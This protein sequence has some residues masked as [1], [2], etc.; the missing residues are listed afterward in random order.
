MKFDRTFVI[1][2]PRQSKRL[3]ATQRHLTER[4]IVAEPFEAFDYTIT[5][6]DTRWPWDMDNP[7]TGYKIGPKIVNLY[8]SHVVLWR[9]LRY[10]DGDAFLILE[11]DVRFD[12]DWKPVF[13]E[14]TA[15]LPPD[16]GMLYP[17]S[18]NTMGKATE[19]V[20]GRLWRVSHV[21]CTHCYAVRRRAL[22]ILLEAC[23]QVWTSLDAAIQMNAR[24]LLNTYAILPPIAVQYATH[25][26]P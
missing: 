13:D 10:L 5:G 7:G 18:C 9:V 21:L 3:A 14:S 20:A 12:R 15:A 22:P 23:Q 1:S 24:P 26:L 19:R 8:L 2:L 17:G 16:W 6:L 11:D 25:L 4:G